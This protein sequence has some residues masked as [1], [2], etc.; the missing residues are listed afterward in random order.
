VCLLSSCWAQTQVPLCAISALE[1]R[2]AGRGGA[3]REGSE[4]GTGACSFVGEGTRSHRNAGKPFLL[5]YKKKK[6][7]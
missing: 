2:E 4:R 6:S 1:D 7:A 5:L 3:R